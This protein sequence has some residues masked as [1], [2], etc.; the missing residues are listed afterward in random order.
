MDSNCKLLVDGA[1]YEHEKAKNA[2]KQVIEAIP[3]Q[4]VGIKA[5]KLN[6]NTL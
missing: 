5:I 4:L 1:Y 2:L 3:S 6:Y